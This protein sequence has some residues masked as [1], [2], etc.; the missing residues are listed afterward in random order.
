MMSSLWLIR[1]LYYSCESVLLFPGLLGYKVFGVY[2][3]QGIGLWGIFWSGG[4]LLSSCC[5]GTPVSWSLLCLLPVC[6]WQIIDWSDL[7]LRK[8]GDCCHVLN[9]KATPFIPYLNVRKSHEMTHR[10]ANAKGLLLSQVFSDLGDSGTVSSHG[11][12]SPTGCCVCA[13]MHDLQPKLMW[14]IAGTWEFLPR[15]AALISWE[16]L[17]VGGGG[18]CLQKLHC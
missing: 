11:F 6:T 13:L 9:H 7:C 3:L 8:H 15:V 2:W 10:G 5:I 14:V 12:G 17:G 4:L 18:P 16:W 1:S